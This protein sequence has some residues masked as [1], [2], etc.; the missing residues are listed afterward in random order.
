[1]LQNHVQVRTCEPL[2][3]FREVDIEGILSILKRFMILI[4]KHLGY[5]SFVNCYTY[6]FI[7][8]VVVTS[9]KCS[10]KQHLECV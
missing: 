7:Y 3:Q 1:M 4:K 2:G 5:I 8:S 10:A 6:I 9:K